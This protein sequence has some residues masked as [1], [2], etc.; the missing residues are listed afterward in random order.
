MVKQNL[1]LNWRKFKTWND[2]CNA[3]GEFEFPCVYVVADKKGK[4]LY[5]GKASARQQ[6]RGGKL[7]AGG[8]RRRY[9][10]DW[11]TLDA[12]MDGSGNLVFVAE[13]K[14][15]KAKDIEAQ[16]ISENHP[17]YNTIGTTTP[18]KRELKILHHGESPQFAHPSETTR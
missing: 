6:S 14:P 7:R 9:W 4:P 1:I 8:L 16:L 12:A 15:A 10:A 5:I 18:P 13:V 17:K 11:N 3:H 2:V